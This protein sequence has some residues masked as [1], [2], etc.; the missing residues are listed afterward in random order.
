MLTKKPACTR[1]R[2]QLPVPPPWPST[3]KN[4]PHKTPQSRLPV[5]SA[6]AE[7][8]RLAQTA[9]PHINLL[10]QIPRMVVCLRLCPPAFRKDKRRYRAPSTE[11]RAYTPR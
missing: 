11:T 10:P 5:Q 6:P 3:P 8:S 2:L 7:A 9:S 1:S 4:H